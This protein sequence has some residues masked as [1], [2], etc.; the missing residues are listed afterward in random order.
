MIEIFLLF[1]GIA[2]ILCVVF[3]CLCIG[4]A[5]GL[6]GYATSFLDRGQSGSDD[7]QY[8]A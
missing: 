5:L 7:R 4:S 3:V 6:V 1:T 2:L 8:S